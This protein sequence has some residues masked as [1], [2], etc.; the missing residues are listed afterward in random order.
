M[1]TS[2]PISGDQ[3]NLFKSP[4]SVRPSLVIWWDVTNRPAAD[5]QLRRVTANR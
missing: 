4:E 2:L 5:G 1:R 3:A